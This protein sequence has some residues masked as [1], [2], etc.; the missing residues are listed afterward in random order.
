MARTTLTRLF[1]PYTT[2]EYELQAVLAAR[3]RRL[4]MMQGHA[5]PTAPGEAP[6]SHYLGPKEDVELGPEPMSLNERRND[7]KGL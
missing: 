1:M 3:K 7:T 5:P 4:Q 6:V 2:P